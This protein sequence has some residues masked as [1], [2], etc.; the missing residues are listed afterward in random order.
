MRVRSKSTLF[1]IVF[2]VVGVDLDVDHLAGVDL[3]QQLL[4][5]LL[6]PVDVFDLARLSSLLLLPLYQLL[7]HLRL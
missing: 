2:D 1:F 3:H 6:H 5:L 4:L 7:S